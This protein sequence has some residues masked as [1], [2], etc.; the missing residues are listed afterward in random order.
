MIPKIWALPL[1]LGG[2][3][4]ATYLLPDVGAVS[5]SAIKMELPDSSGYWSFRH[6]PPSSAE[7][8]ALSAD[9]QFSKAIC[10][11]A[12]FGEYDADGYLI[13]DRVDL[14]IVLSGVDL[15]NSIH[16][17]ERCMPAQGHTIA[18]S[19]SQTLT[20]E[21]GRALP[22]KRLVSVQSQQIAKTAD[23]EEYVKLKCITYYF[24]VGNKAITNDHLS[25]TAI[26]MKDRLLYG[27][28]QRWAYT[29]MSMWYGKVPWIEVEISE[30]EATEKLEAFVKDV[31]EQQ[32]NWDQIQP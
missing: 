6:L 18:S 29:S 7:L 20:L 25:R 16:R 14:S 23:R 21:N 30:Q 5:Q 19:R 8:S 28:D 32:I 1:I 12:R 11:R 27:M 31:A 10:Q 22:V 2:L 15:N 13:P 24:F 26:D 9:T 3:L 4:G 17:P